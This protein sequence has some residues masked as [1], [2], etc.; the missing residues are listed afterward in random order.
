MFM[1][2]N[3]VR[4][5]ISTSAVARSS[6][7]KTRPQYKFQSARHRIGKHGQRLI[8][9]AIGIYE[10]RNNFN[11]EDGYELSRAQKSVIG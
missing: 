11:R 6:L 8:W 7:K 10:N 3:I 1:K 9:E 5:L 4:K 2:A